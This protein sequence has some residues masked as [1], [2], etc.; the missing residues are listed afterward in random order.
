VLY[1]AVVGRGA[2][3]DL[4]TIDLMRR[5]GIVPVPAPH[6]CNPRVSRA[7]SR[8][9][10]RLLSVDRDARP[11]SAGEVEREL[12]RLG[13]RRAV[14]MVSVDQADQ[15]GLEDELELVRLG[16]RRPVRLAWV[17][18]TLVVLAALGLTWY[19]RR[20][21]GDDGG[22]VNVPPAARYRGQVD[23][24]VFRKGADGFANEVRLDDIRAMPV[25]TGDR[26][27]I[28]AEVQPEAYLYLFWVHPSGGEVEPVYPWEPGQWG[29]RPKSETPVSRLR[30]PVEGGFIFNDDVRGLE[31]LVL[32]ARPRPLAA[33]E[34]EIQ[35]W[36][37]GLT[38]LG[39]VPE[40]RMVV[41]FQNGQE[42][43]D[44]PRFQKRF[45]P[46]DNQAARNALEQ[47]RDLQ[48]RLKPH[49]AFRAAVSF[50]R[51]GKE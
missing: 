15:S 29:S 8:L 46:V 26:F 45:F 22:G 33:G 49:A 50:A 40:E 36:F 37:A 4:P 34:K 16:W 51:Q 23:V 31:T 42:V 19:L 14:R 13:R 3:E 39:Q 1:E 32:L 30:L 6:Q 44:D 35:S 21:A 27:Y 41:W 9:I 18:V 10:E 47:L 24:R 20:P 12:V 48:R 17:G 25:R 28:E 38:A 43:N 11:R 7:L 2:F 5:G